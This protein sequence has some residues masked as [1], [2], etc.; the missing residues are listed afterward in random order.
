MGHPPIRERRRNHIV[1]AGPRNG[2][3]LSW[4][5]L[6]RPRRQQ[7]RR[8]RRGCPDRGHLHK[9]RRIEPFRIW[10][11]EGFASFNCV[12]CGLAGFARDGELNAP[13]PDPAR[14]AAMRSA[15]AQHDA[16]DLAERKAR[17]AALWA[18]SFRRR[19]GRAAGGISGGA[20]CPSGSLAAARPWRMCCAG[21]GPRAAS[22]PSCAMPSRMNHAA[23]ITFLDDQCAKLDR[24]ML[25][26]AGTI[27]LS[28]DEAVAEGLGI[29]EGV[30]DGLSLMLR[31]WRPIWCL[32]SAGGI[33][34]FPVLGGIEALT[35][36]AHNDPTGLKAAE[37]CAERWRAAGREATIMPPAQAEDWGASHVLEHGRPRRHRRSHYRRTGQAVR[38][39]QPG[40]RFRGA[41][42]TAIPAAGGGRGSSRRRAGAVARR[43]RGHRRA[44]TGRRR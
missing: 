4:E 5:H 13:R 6:P 25:G 24:R 29:V 19:R 7:D 15:K 27:K 17:A 38:R 41:A 28:A 34:R 16:A 36:F 21:I 20:G 39:Y 18:S 44:H 2:P 43:H 12:R 32:A 26:T 1:P 31:G 23:C 8:V 9:P 30:E 22:S 14:I 37:A 11:A 3:A 42:A 40:K 33:E 35:I 10:R